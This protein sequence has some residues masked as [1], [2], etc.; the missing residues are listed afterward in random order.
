MDTGASEN[1]IRKS[2]VNKMGLSHQ[3]EPSKLKVVVKL[4]T[5]VKKTIPKCRLT[6]T[7]NI[8]G[9]QSKESFY[10]IDMDDKFDVIIG[11]PWFTK[12]KPQ[13]N[14]EKGSLMT[15][16]VSDTIVSTSQPLSVAMSTMDCDGAKGTGTD[17]G[18]DPLDQIEVHSISKND[19]IDHGVNRGILKSAMTSSFK[20][21]DR[22]IK[23]CVSFAKKHEFIIIDDNILGDNDVRD[24]ESVI[25]QN[26]SVGDTRNR[27]PT[28]SKIINNKG[29]L[30]ST[31]SALIANVK[32]VN[33]IHFIDEKEDG[34][35]TSTIEVTVLANGI[36]L[37]TQSQILESPPT[38]LKEI[39]NLPL[40]SNEEFLGDLKLGHIEQVCT[41]STSNEDDDSEGPTVLSSS[42][43]DELVLNEKTKVE[44]FDTQGWD[45]LKGSPFYELLREFEDVFP[46]EIP[47]SLP[48]DKGI[49]HEIDLVPGTK[50][51]VTRQWPLPKEQVKVIDDFFAERAKAGHVRES[52]SPHCSPTFCVKK[53]TGGWRIV[54]AFNKLNAATVPAQTPIP[55][56]D[57]ILDSMQGSTIFSTLDL[58]DSYYQILMRESDI[59]LTA[60]ST[61]SGMLW[62]WLVMPQGLSN[63]PATFNRCVSHLFRPCRDFA[64]SYFDDIFIHSRASA[65][66]TELDVHLE[67]LRE[68]LTIMRANRL[69]ANIKKCIFGVDEI[70]VLGCYVG[71]KGVRVDPEK[72]KA[73]VDWPVPQ[74]VK[75]LRKWL[76]LANYLHKYTKNY[77]DIV[78]PLSSLLRKDAEWHWGSEQNDAFEQIKR[79]LIEA[80]ILG[81]PNQDRPFHVVCDASDFAIGCALLQIDEEGHE[82]VISYQSRQLRPAE[83]NY[84]VH[85]KE[86]LAMKYALVKFRVYLLGSKPFVIYTDHASLRT[87]VNTPHLSQRMARWL[88]FFS[89]YNF[90]VEYKPG[91]INHLADALS[92]RPDYKS[93]DTLSVHGNTIHSVQTRL[94][95]D[96]KAAYVTDEYCKQLLQHFKV[97][98]PAVTKKLSPKIQ[99]RLHRYSYL[100]DMLY[101]SLDDGDHPRILV[102]HKEELKR[103]ILYE[104]HDVPSAGHLGREKTFLA[105]SRDYYWPHLYKWVRHYVRTCEVCQRVKPSRSLQA[106]LQSLPIARDC[107]KSVSLDF[108][109]GFPP[110]AQQRTGILVFVDRFSKMVHLVPVMDTITAEESAQHFLDT[111]FRLH[112]MPETIVSDRDP[113]FT[114]GFWKH[115]FHL[116]G[117]KLTMSTTA[118]PET[119]GQTERVNRVLVSIFRSYAATVYKDWS[120]L[121][122][123]AEFAINNAVHVS[124]GYTP[125][126]VNHLVHPRLPISLSGG[127]HEISVGGNPSDS[128]IHTESN[129]RVVE[130]DFNPDLGHPIEDVSVNDHIDQGHSHVVPTRLDHD[131]GGMNEGPIDPTSDIPM[132]IE[133]D[134]IGQSTVNDIIHEMYD[135]NEV[136]ITSGGSLVTS[137]IAVAVSQF[138]DKRSAIIKDIQDSLA[139]AVDRQK[140]Q[141]DKKGRKLFNKFIIGDKVLLSTKG[142]P[143]SAVSNYGSSKLLPN[144]I[145]PFTVVRVVNDQAYTLS[146]PS[147]MKLHPT[148]YV[149][150]L[151]P[152][153]DSTDFVESGSES[154]VGD[155]AP[156]RDLSSPNEDSR[157]PFGDP[158]TLD[159]SG[160]AIQSVHPPGSIGSE[161]LFQPS[162]LLERGPPPLVDS[163]GNQRWIVEKIL[164]QRRRSGVEEL[165]VKWLG[166]P[167]PS[168]EPLG[169][170]MA[171][172][173]DLVRKYLDTKQVRGR[174]ARTGTH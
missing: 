15:A 108:I 46:D 52:K 172:V 69:F 130:M 122:P 14:W 138:L 38:K 16:N 106:P 117:T 85:D 39:L 105:V 76:G 49:R 92:R 91:R 119:D 121:L 73:V 152:Y 97:L 13:F 156:A 155:E 164:G 128:E 132:D 104:Y 58:R 4:A 77:A 168:W 60:V 173:P 37:I 112:G 9:F 148:F 48:K 70:P 136:D 27:V 86:L 5:G 59:P 174:R 34:S 43:N 170:L 62:E 68:V 17:S 95:D 99:S 100:N 32:N 134:R 144:Y 67:H 47:C 93:S 146:I 165:Q 11:M 129:D 23:R 162:E 1:F 167:T 30:R 118:H 87:A 125:F 8:S 24:V 57:V 25:Q 83:R 102:P 115:L 61:P 109:F 145:G 149:G 10:V 126:Y 45:S 120:K 80:P 3:V 74:N 154:F 127:S 101:Y 36:E 161:L 153:V 26:N 142:L 42:V 35:V 158:E 98:D 96:I 81:L 140:E 151:K 143:A 84:P 19:Q 123:M 111:V 113:R 150:L 169:S 65:T 116:V 63:A 131:I 53:A 89:E 44:R 31:R 135:I 147:K 54:H 21:T 159:R 107:W 137:K 20:V 33:D 28:H 82:R 110:D 78:R 88:S 114:G 50:Y 71:K 7:L 6:L 64:P 22:V 55:R 41:L 124:H 18:V 133:E 90:K 166:Y 160:Q 171:D 139:S 2:F 29:T 94:H 72:V 12:H 56:K 163:H 51:C 141:A 40:I 79:S 157:S 66:Q 103:R 75:Q